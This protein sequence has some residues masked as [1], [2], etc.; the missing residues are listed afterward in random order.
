MAPLS[1]RRHRRS[2]ALLLLLLGLAA[3]PAALRAQQ[4]SEASGS[5]VFLQPPWKVD[6]LSYSTTTWQVRAEYYFTVELPAGA[7]A[8]LGGLTIQQTRGVDRSFQFQVERTRAFL[9][10]PRREAAAVP[11]Q[12]SFDPDQRL[13]TVTFPQPVAP[14]STVTVVL[15][16]WTNPGQADTYM[17]QVTA[18]PAG[19]NPEP[20]ALG[21]GTLRIYPP[22]WR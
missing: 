7:G 20:S 2:A 5:T 6:L 14:G 22:D 11:V 9:G 15:R 8:P 3:G 16:P 10:R 12:A 1:W 19:A 4:A 13:F 17:F 18:W 21:F